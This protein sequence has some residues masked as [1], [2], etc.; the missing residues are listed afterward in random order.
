M[1]EH[2]RG[3]WTQSSTVLHGG[4]NHLHLCIINREVRQLQRN[5]VAN[6]PLKAA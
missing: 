4:G 5:V 1:V 6:Y 2:I 3:G